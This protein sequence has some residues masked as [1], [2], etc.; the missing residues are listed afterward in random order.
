MCVC[1]FVCVCVTIFADWP[2]DGKDRVILFN[3]STGTSF[4]I[5]PA[6]KAMAHTDIHSMHS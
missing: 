3:C 1:V 4:E 6:A 5:K 2:M